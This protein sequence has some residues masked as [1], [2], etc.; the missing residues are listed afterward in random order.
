MV[1]SRYSGTKWKKERE[2]AANAGSALHLDS[3]AVGL[4]DGLGDAEA[5]AGA[6][7]LARARWIHAIESLED[8]RQGLRSDPDAGIPHFDFR[9]VR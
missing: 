6:P 5:Q 1:F 3:T 9:P 2:R 7:C 4:G 8:S